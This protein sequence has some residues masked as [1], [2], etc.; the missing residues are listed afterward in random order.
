MYLPTGHT[1]RWTDGWTGRPTDGWADRKTAK[2][3]GRWADCRT[4]GQ[5]DRQME[6][7]LKMLFR[8]FLVNL[9][10]LLFKIK[11]E[12]EFKRLKIS[13]KFKNA[14]SEF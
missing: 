13:I 7:N 2:Y 3:A 14:F 9:K 8:T 6:G 5:T 1:D 4:D 11:I 12:T 10:F